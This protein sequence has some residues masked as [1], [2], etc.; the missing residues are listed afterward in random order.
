M[1]VFLKKLSR[2]VIVLTGATSGIGL[3]TARMA[4]Q[5]GAKLV[6]AARNEPALRELSNQL[7]RGGTEVAYVVADVG[8]EEDVRQIANAAIERFGRIDTWINNAGVSIFGRHEEVT[9]EDMR[10]L[11]ETNFWGVVHG[12]LTALPHLKAHGGAL[13]NVGSGFSDRAAPLQGMYSASKHAV[14]GFTDSLRM[15]LEKEGAPV[16]VTLIKPA[17]VNSM[18]TEHA[19]NYLDVRPRLPPPLYAPEVVA[20]A[21]LYAAEHPVRDIYAGGAARLLALGAYHLPRLMDWSME[22][23]MFKFQRT[24]KLPYPAHRHN[25]HSASPDMQ[26]RSASD[27]HV[28]ERSWYTDTVTSS[29]ARNAVLLGS[30]IALALLWRKRAASSQAALPA[31]TGSQAARMPQG[32]Q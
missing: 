24:D 6:L 2:Q 25:L 15:E 16:S 14:K 32:S 30:G 8:I 10:K 29:A 4:A 12:S 28:F 11:F 22:R 17:S 9:I 20:R 21:I 5:R 23:L 7:A 3:T 31:V 27:A 13:L 18:L 26:E 1:R 19:R